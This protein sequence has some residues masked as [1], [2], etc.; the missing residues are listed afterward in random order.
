MFKITT[1]IRSLTWKLFINMLIFGIWFSLFS[2]IVKTN[3]NEDIFTWS[4]YISSSPIFKI[5]YDLTSPNI[6]VWAYIYLEPEVLYAYWSTYTMINEDDSGPG[7]QKSKNLSKV[8][9]VFRKKY[10]KNIQCSRT[11]VKKRSFLMHFLC[12]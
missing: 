10:L 8:S 1:Y 11:R 3:K 9:K 5:D 7:F 6:Y 12:C 4:W 2:C